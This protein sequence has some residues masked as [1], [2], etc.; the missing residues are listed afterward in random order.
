VTAIVLSEGK[1]AELSVRGSQDH[2]DREKTMS[3][4]DTRIFS[5]LAV[6][7]LCVS[8]GRYWYLFKPLTAVSAG[9]FYR[10]EHIVSYSS[11]KVVA[12]SAA[13]QSIGWKETTIQS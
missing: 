9:R 7:R 10:F 5:P 2:P 11:F 13:Q 6:P 3:D 12:K 4:P 1:F 8:I